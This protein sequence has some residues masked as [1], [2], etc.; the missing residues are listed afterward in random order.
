MPDIRIKDL[1][2]LGLPNGTEALPTDA[3]VGGTRKID[4]N[5][6]AAFAALLQPGA[7]FVFQPGGVD[8]RNVYTSF[9]ALQAAASGVA[10]GQPKRIF[11]DGTFNGGVVTIPAGSWFFAGEY[12]I[13]GITNGGGVAARP[14]VVFSPNCVFSRWPALIEGILITDQ[15][16][17]FSLFG[18]GGGGGGDQCRLVQVDE[19]GTAG[20]PLFLTTVG[21]VTPRIFLER[22]IV[23]LGPLLDTIAVPSSAFVY[24]LGGSV[25]GQNTVAANPTAN[26]VVDAS[27]RASAVQTG[28]ASVEAV[29][30]W[31]SQSTFVYDSAA[32]PP[33]PANTYADW[34]TL[35]ELL[36]GI[37]GDITLVFPHDET[38]PTNTTYNFDTQRVRWLGGGNAVAAGARPSL[39]G[40]VGVEVRGVTCFEHLNLQAQDGTDLLRSPSGAQAWHYDFRNASAEATGAVAAVIRHD[41]QGALTI[42]LW[43]D[44]NFFF[45]GVAPIVRGVTNAPGSFAINAYDE[46]QIDTN[47]I[48]TPALYAATLRTLSSA[49]AFG[50]QAGMAGVT[51]FFLGPRDDHEGHSITI[52][53]GSWALPNPTTVQEAIA[54]LA[55]AVAGLLGGPIP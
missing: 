27:S 2:A 53:A 24:V 42:N 36:G 28:S 3:L 15:N 40:N 5:G 14:S 50:P 9:A 4:L 18:N 13:I 48:E 39:L 43:G 11:L 29:P 33:L 20:L 49:A 51:T 54:R 21:G 31:S 12:Q 45:S 38:I 7:D 22:S 6:I 30:E 32:A 16:A 1:P 10:A 35:H 55:V 34:D 8:A 23:E 44:S 47:V 25:L 26:I 19:I 17:L 41:Q 46:A 37:V 52:D